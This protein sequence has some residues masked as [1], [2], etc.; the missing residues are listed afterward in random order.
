MDARLAC[1]DSRR[2]DFESAM[3][4]LRS[5][6]ERGLERA[7][8]LIHALRPV[9]RC[10][11]VA[12]VL[13]EIAPP[14]EHL[15]ADVAA[16]RDRLALAG[17][18]ASM[19]AIKDSAEEATSVLARARDL[20]YRP[21]LAE[22]LTVWGGNPESA[23]R[24]KRER[25]LQDA[26]WIALA[27][28]DTAT[29]LEATVELT[30]LRRNVGRIED[31]LD[32]AARARALLVGGDDPATRIRLDLA[33]ALAYRELAQFDDARPYAERAY[34]R[35]VQLYGESSPRLANPLR[36]LAALEIAAGNHERALELANLTLALRE[37]SLGPKHPHT[38]RALEVVAVALRSLQRYEEAESILRRA[39][40]IEIEASGPRSRSVATLHN[41]LGNLYKKTGRP[42][43]ARRAY[44]LAASIWEERGADDSVVYALGN[45][46]ELDANAGKIEA[47]LK[48]YSKAWAI[49]EST[50]SGRHA[51]RGTIAYHIGVIK[52]AVE[53]FE[54]AKAWL[55]RS[56][57]APGYRKTSV[58]VSQAGLAYVEGKLGHEAEAVRLAAEA[59][60]V[61]GDRKIPIALGGFEDTVRA[62]AAKS[63]RDASPG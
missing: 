44:E 51:L 50:P 35:A 45:I 57:E 55:E 6:P 10:G 15:V 31:T 7:F 58:A 53:D 21:L 20:G 29:A 28:N 13:E 18:Q 59:I 46:A 5:P 42:A 16:A 62:L 36:G 41:N 61:L 43:E 22:A 9:E 23:D 34:R 11:N 49:I 56:I 40:S 32:W 52:L 19:G 38:A 54:A 25:A 1:L 48:N 33:L 37:S 12:A 63:T 26:A 8:D 14:P 30:R 4:V 47:S 24:D 17:S 2:R 3:V 39:L 60:A 27:E